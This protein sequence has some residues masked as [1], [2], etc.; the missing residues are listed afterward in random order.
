M[1]EE[2]EIFGPIDFVLLEYPA[3]R[4]DGSVA[5][6]VLDLVEAGTIRL[7]DVVLVEKNAAGD[8]RAVEVTELPVELTG[9][10]V[11]I[12]GARSG[13]VGDED[14]LAAAE[15]LEPG[16]LAALLVYENAWAIPFIAASIRSGGAVVA[17]GRIPYDVVFEVV[18]ALDDQD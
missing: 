1:S 15:A 12:A 10:L 13:L 16:T 5:R 6:T 8:V 17:N 7:W 9:A 3:D 18:D 14:V 11:D 2:P 4:L